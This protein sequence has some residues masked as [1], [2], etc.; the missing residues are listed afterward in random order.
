M[1]RVVCGWEVFAIRRRSSGGRG[2]ILVEGVNFL[3]SC[4]FFEDDGNQKLWT[5]REDP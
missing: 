1:L 3:M 4:N 5:K 2:G